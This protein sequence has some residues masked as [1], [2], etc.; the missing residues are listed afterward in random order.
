MLELAGV[1]VT[2]G[3]RSACVTVTEPVPVVLAYVAS[4]LYATARVTV[5]APNDP[6]G[7]V[8]LALPVPSSVTFDEVYPPPLRLTVP[9]GVPLLPET[10][11]LTVRLCAVVME[12]EDGVTVTVAA[13]V[14][15]AAD[16]YLIRLVA[17]TLPIPVARS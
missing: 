4:P 5:P 2:V 3:V 12:L 13:A 8:K 11:T 16:Q 17:S 15:T 10:V 1:T 14:P 7:T 9:V 6:A